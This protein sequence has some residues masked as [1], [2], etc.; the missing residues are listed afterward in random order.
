VRA[1][2]EDRTP[3]SNGRGG[4]KVV[5]ILVGFLESQAAGHTPVAIPERRGVA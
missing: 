2:D 4:Q 3:T 1:V 5:E